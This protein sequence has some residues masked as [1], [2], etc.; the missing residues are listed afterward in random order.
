[1]SAFEMQ[2]LGKIMLVTEVGEGDAIV[3]AV[4]KSVAIET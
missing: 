2:A 1:M 4:L 3:R